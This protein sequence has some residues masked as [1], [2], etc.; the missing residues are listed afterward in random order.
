MTFVEKP[1]LDATSSSSWSHTLASFS[2]S[3][4]GHYTFE[5]RAFV[6]VKIESKFIFSENRWHIQRA[7]CP[8]DV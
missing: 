8:F 3:P 2:A 5:G 7:S 1:L 4:R 6:G